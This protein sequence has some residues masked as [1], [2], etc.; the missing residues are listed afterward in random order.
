MGEGWATTIALATAVISAVAWGDTASVETRSGRPT[1]LVNGQPTPPFAY[2]SYLGKETYYREVAE[3]GI[4]LYCFPAY[5]GDRGINPH[6]GIGPFR[7]AIWRGDNEYDFSSLTADFE[8]L[9]KADPQANAIIRIHLDPPEWWERAHQEGSCQLPDGTTFRQCFASPLWRES[10]ANALRACIDWLNQSPYVEHLVGI[11]VAAGRT[12]E[13]F[14]HQRGLYFDLN[15]ARAKAFRN[16]LRST[17]ADDVERLRAAWKA[18]DINFDSAT[19]ADISGEKRTETWRDPKESQPIIDTFRFH[20]QTIVK[21]IAFFCRIVKEESKKPLL[22]GAFY[23]YHYFVNDPRLGHFA[24]GRLLKCPH[25]DYLSSPNV[26]HRVMGEDWPP[27]VAQASVA[28]HG[29]LW[30]AEN[31]TRTCRTTL[32]KD[33]APEICPPGYYDTGVW[34]GP[35]S[36]EE[37][38]ALL[39]KNTARMLTGGYGGWWFDMWGGWFSGPPLI[40]VLQRTQELGRIA[41]QDGAAEMHAQVCV[42]ADEELSF[43]D[44]S[45]GALTGRIVHNRYALGRT[46]APYDLYLRG[47]FARLPASRY[48]AVWLLGQLELTKAEAELIEAWRASGTTILWTQPTGSTILRPDGTE[49]WHAGKIQWS[50]EEIRALWHAAG[51]HVY[52][53]SDDVLYAGNGWLSVHTVPGGSRTVRLPFMARV[54]DA[55]TGQVVAEGTS[56]LDLTLPP[57][58]TTLFRVT[59]TTRTE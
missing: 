43:L 24:L 56:Q 29:K 14:Y 19:L 40:D 35:E 5:L 20:A 30:L 42:I 21:D 25:V 55:F 51:V 45:F 54:E 36:V 26:Y 10:T 41:L 18:P 27:M 9:L 53:N 31:D 22:T 39:R 4:H 57:K 11:H 16:W 23:G 1:L 44:N 59:H 3:A 50:P 8:A 28:L 13:W 58:S 12:E 46:G 37:S 6:S 7:P 38:V 49:T 32:L 33:Q 15:P 52:L 34:V 2:M 48:R 17:Y 47:D